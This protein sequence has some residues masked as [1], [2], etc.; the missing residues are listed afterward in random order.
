METVSKHAPMRRAEPSVTK[1][2]REGGWRTLP[3]L[4]WAL[5]VQWD[6]TARSRRALR[7]MTP[8]QLKDIGLDQSA[9]RR[10]SAKGSWRF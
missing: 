8:E 10:E 2:G 1:T 3:S 4:L 7:E 9:A 5:Y 6:Q